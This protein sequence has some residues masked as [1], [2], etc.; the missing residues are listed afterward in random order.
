MK[1]IVIS[2]LL[3]VLFIFQG[4]TYAQ[5]LVPVESTIEHADKLRPCLLVYVDPEPKTL[6]KAWRDFL[7]EKYNFKLKGIGFLSNKDVLRAKEVMLP[8]ISPN[9]LDFYT[10]IVPDANGSQM[11]VFASYGYEVYI[12]PNEHPEAFQQL[13]TIFS[14]FLQTYIPN[15]YQELVN[16]TEDAVNGLMKDQKKLKKSITK[17]SKKVEKFTAKIKQLNEAVSDNQAELVEVEEK[18]SNRTLKL[19]KYKLKLKNVMN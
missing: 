7:K 17:D 3:S 16:D 2:F 12:D 1:Y 18:L 9:A 6:K 8:A 11:K 15:Y 10:E 19:E 13:K 5:N 14:T 4:T